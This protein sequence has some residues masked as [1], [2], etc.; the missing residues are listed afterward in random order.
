MP[1]LHLSFYMTIFPTSSY[2]A[3]TFFKFFLQKMLLF[4]FHYGINF[5]F[6]LVYRYKMPPLK[7]YHKLLAVCYASCSF[8]SLGHPH[9]HSSPDQ[10]LPG[11]LPKPPRAS[12]LLTFWT[13]ALPK[14]NMGPCC[15]RARN[16]SK[17]FSEYT[18]THSV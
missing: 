7:A 10:L 15:S 4:L 18:T 5:Y 6:K 11:P 9:L 12:L 17:A 2:L 14:W 13:P 1:Q 8:S 16:S 3:H